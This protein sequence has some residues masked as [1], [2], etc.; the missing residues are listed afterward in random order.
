MCFTLDGKLVALNI[1]VGKFHQK[2]ISPRETHNGS[3]PWYI[4]SNITKLGCD[5]S[6]LYYPSLC[7]A[8]PIYKTLIPTEYS[9]DSVGAIVERATERLPSLNERMARWLAQNENQA[10]DEKLQG[11][12]ARN[13]GL[14]YKVCV[15]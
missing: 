11:S 14:S 7:C 6:I 3:I 5:T 12:F 8:L 2:I 15:S 4:K 10:A 13:D 9:P 1:S